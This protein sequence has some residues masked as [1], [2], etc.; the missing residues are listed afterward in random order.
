MS[1]EEFHSAFSAALNMMQRN[2]HDEYDKRVVKEI[3]KQLRIPFDKDSYESLPQ[4]LLTHVGAGL[5]MMT[6]KAPGP[7]SMQLLTSKKF[8]SSAVWKTYQDA[9]ENY[10][11]AGTIAVVF[12]YHGDG[13]GDLVMHN[14]PV[15]F[16]ADSDWALKIMVNGQAYFVQSLKSFISKLESVSL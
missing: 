8:S 2:K 15:K 1:N 11:K 14:N 9:A 3:C 16:T 12:D 13:L 6:K 4:F 10:S 7:I 5:G